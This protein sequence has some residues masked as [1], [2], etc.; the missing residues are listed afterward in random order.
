MSTNGTFWCVCILIQ[1]IKCLMHYVTVAFQNYWQKQILP[2]IETQSSSA[3]PMI[4]ILVFR[5]R[6]GLITEAN[7]LVKRETPKN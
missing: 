6:L 7:L 1:F 2:A 3:M 4:D 5:S